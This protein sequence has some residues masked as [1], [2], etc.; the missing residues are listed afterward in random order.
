MDATDSQCECMVCRRAPESSLRRDYQSPRKTS[1]VYPTAERGR[2]QLWV[3]PRSVWFRRGRSL[4][5]LT[6]STLLFTSVSGVHDARD[7][8]LIVDMHCKAV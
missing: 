3:T 8:R 4:L 7:A 6:R 5:I 2:Q 1:A